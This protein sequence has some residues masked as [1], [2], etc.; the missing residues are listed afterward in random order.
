LWW[1]TLIFTGIVFSLLHSYLYLDSFIFPTEMWQYVKRMIFF[2]LALYISFKRLMTARRFFLILAGAAALS[3]M[4]GLLQAN[5]S[6]IGVYL[7]KVYQR[8]HLQIRN[9]L[10]A[11]YLGIRVYG[12][13]GHSNA[14]GGL[15]MFFF[16]ALMPALLADSTSLSQKRSLAKAIN[17]LAFFL[18]TLMALVNVLLSMSR[19]AILAALAA[20]GLVMVLGFHVSRRPARFVFANVALFVMIAILFWGF[21]A[22]KILSFYDRFVVLTGVEL[23]GGHNARIEQVE[24]ALGLLRN[25]YDY[26]FGVGNALARDQTSSWGT[27]VEYVH[28]LAVYGVFGCILRYGLAL[29]IIWTAWKQVDTSA[30]EER[31]LAIGAI[32]AMAGYLTF[33]LGYFFFSDIAVG[34]PPWLL[35]GWVVGAYYRRQRE[36]EEV[37]A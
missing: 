27:E 4:V 29:W 36:L 7:A 9:I 20:Y 34:T 21:M 12:V 5:Q 25:W 8:G 17:W 19:G 26:A 6:G 1:I 11:N 3:L 23:E 30:L 10:Y 32:A 31:A 15:A 33:S 16:A 18:V 14:W 24:W 37:S 2:Y 35:F 13:A 22:D 28:M